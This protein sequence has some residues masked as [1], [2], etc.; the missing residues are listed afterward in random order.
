MAEANGYHTLA[1]QSSDRGSFR[2]DKLCAF[3]GFG[4]Y[5]GAEDIPK[6]GHEVGNPNYGVWDGD[7]L[8]FLSSKLHTIK[9]PF[10]SFAF[11]ASTHAPFYSPGKEWEKYPHSTQ[12]EYG[13]LNTM[14]YMDAQIDAFMKRSAHEPWFENT[15]FIFTADH[16]NHAE[17]SS[18][19]E[20][21]KKKV[22]L[23]SYHI[24]LIIYAPK[25]YEPKVIETLGSHVDILPTLI[26]ILGWQ[27]SFTTISSSL[28][29]TSVKQRFAFVKHGG[30]VALTD[31]NA[32]VHYNFNTFMKEDAK[33]SKELESL[34]LSIDTA[35]ANLLKQKK[36]MQE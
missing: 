29:D 4:E 28:F 1:M 18:A 33:S 21:K 16:T 20:V 7:M 13:F 31:A 23:A 27:Q 30:E 17:G 36:W 12:S 22:E 32:S 26:D 10:I 25:I 24:P 14:N 5:Y 9:E 19:A 6:S 35:Q 3:A 34:L 2:V 11:S 8:R 15:I